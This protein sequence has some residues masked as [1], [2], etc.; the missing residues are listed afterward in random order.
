VRLQTEREQPLLRRDAQ[1]AR[2]S[3]IEPVLPRRPGDRVRWSGLAG[4]AAG[5]AIARAAGQAR[6][7]FVVIAPDS[8]ALDRLEGEL[9]F[10]LGEGGDLPVLRFPDWETLPY[11]LF[12]PHQDIV[13]DRLGALYRLASLERGVLLVSAT[14]A[15]GRLAPREYLEAQSLVVDP[16]QRLDVEQ[17]RRRLEAAGYRCVG[18]VMEH[19]EF[20][21]RGSLIDLFPM[22][23]ATPFRIDLLDDRVDSLRTFD[24]ETQRSQQRVDA[25]R[26]LPA[27]EFPLDEAGIARFRQTWR[28][29]FAGDPSAAPIY[30]DVSKGLAPGGIEY[31]LPLFFSRTCGLFDYLPAEVVVL[32]LEGVAESLDVYW[33]QI[34]DRYEQGRYDRERPLLPPGEIFLAPNEFFAA[35]TPFAQIALVGA[36]P[37]DEARGVPFDTQ[38]PPALPV[39]AHGEDPLAALRAYLQTFAGRVLLLA[40]TAGRRETLLELLGSHG[41]QPV[42]VSGWPEFRDG[43]QTFAIA[44]AGL[45]RGTVLGEP[46]LALITETQL[47]GERAQQRRRRAAT[48]RD[49]EGLV[50]DLAELSI[51]APVVHEDHGVGRYRGL[52][53][54]AVGDTTTEF[55]CIEY[56]DADRLYVPVAS[57]HLVSR[58]TGADPDLA[59]L[60]KLGGSQWQKAKRKAAEQ[61]RD[62]AAELLELHARRAARKGHA[63][64]LDPLAYEAFAQAFPFEETPD[65][66]AAIEAVVA[67]MTSPR[68]MDRLVCGD[69]GFGKTEVAMRA[70][71]VAVHAGWQVA[72][73]VPT[74]LLAQQHYQNFRDRFADWPVRVEQLSRFR[75]KK[76]L[77]ATARD[78]A[79]GKVD[80]VIGTHKLLQEGLRF[81]RL[82]LVVIDEE[83]RFGVRHKE[84]FKALRAEVDVLTLTATPIPRTLHMALSGLRDLSLIATPPARRLSIK[85]FV[86]T[87]DDRLLREGCLREIK[88][89]GQVFFVHNEI[90]TIDR[91]A[92]QVGALV[93][94]ATLRIAHGQMRER[95]LERVMLDFYH[96]RFNL[97]V[98]TTIIET[99]ID[100]P[101]ANTILVNRADRFGLAQLHQLRGRVGRSHHRAYAYLLVPHPR[102]LTADAVKRLEAIESLEDLGIGFT[103]ATHDLEIRGAGELLG[104]EQSGQMQEVGYALYTE[105][106][107]RAVQALKAGRSPELDRP[108]DHGAE[109]DL[110]VPA[111][112]P[113]D[114]L[115]DIHTRLILYKRI[116]SAASAE[117]LRRL[118]EEMIDRFGLLP[119]PTRLLFRATAF[120]LRATPIGI[121][122]ADVGSRGGRV[123]FGPDPAVDATRI[124]QLIQ[125]E[126]GR[127][128]LE[129]GDRLRLTME[130]PDSESRVRA[131]DTLLDRLGAR[132]LA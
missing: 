83:H 115:P 13:S 29:R 47:F 89:G 18:Q 130:L 106:L 117:D 95:E 102:A 82:G 7:P 132:A 71:F 120:K 73:L 57:L 17:L 40:E 116:A 90:E 36:G 93:P 125:K 87:W 94:E 11:D 119:E 105:L 109:I 77:E 78:L 43:H 107:D 118:Q 33:R 6:A 63:F 67:D 84:R 129:G 114:Y 5:L 112:I 26:L 42:Q 49:P 12:S 37:G 96:R 23:S 121:R 38:D 81:K 2:L 25:I 4:S 8:P 52:Q 48:T 85:T 108:L 54:L 101:N 3:P 86:H 68:P 99:G 104:H 66:R 46:R 60:H 61:V 10:Y 9:R 65:Q 131:L 76:D 59:P 20:A 16:G 62:V 31:Y 53:T 97:L 14:T 123:L 92:E 91:I 44:V 55:L 110:H 39:E 19:G 51:G 80:I 103:L 41:L 113:E 122:K 69:V 74:T 50:R 28:E 15:M 75:A 58:Y 127:Y 128:R 88:R 30:R 124:I 45:E 111:L 1:E 22:G 72:V 24:P 79:E 100:V 70:A 32:R 21:V 34:Q 98:C 64:H 126:P 35:L 56:A 27:R